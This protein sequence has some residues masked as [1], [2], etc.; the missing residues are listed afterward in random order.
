MLTRACTTNNSSSTFKAE[1]LRFPIASSGVDRILRAL[2]PDDAEI[3]FD[4][5][6]AEITGK[7][8]RYGFLLTR[9]FTM[10]E[11]K[12]LITEKKL[13]EPKPT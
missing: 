9:N 3:P 11:S 13:V 8:G 5:I 6:L 1:N 10:L 4:W 7:R 12:H 2:P